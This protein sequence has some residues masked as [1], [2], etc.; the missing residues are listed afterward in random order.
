MG[1]KSEKWGVRLVVLLESRSF[2]VFIAE[3][4]KK[5]KESQT[6]SRQKKVQREKNTC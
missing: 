5:K 2:Y 1:C 3:H 4:S 6:I